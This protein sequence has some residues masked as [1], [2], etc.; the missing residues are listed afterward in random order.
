MQDLSVTPFS[1]YGSYLSISRPRQENSVPGAM[2]VQWHA[3]RAVDDRELFR[4]EVLCDGAVVSCDE[5]FDAGSLRL[6]HA[7]G[8]IAFGIE[9]GD[10][11]RVHGQGGL[12]LRLRAKLGTAVVAHPAEGDTWVV[13]HRPS[14]THSLIEP[15]VG[16][17]AVDA[18][19]D[20]D[21]ASRI[22]V[23]LTPDA[24]GNFDTAIDQ[25]QSTWVPGDRPAFDAVVESSAAHFADWLTRQPDVPDRLA[26]AREHAAYVNWALMV[27]PRGMLKRPSM[28]MSK[29]WMDQV[30][31]WDHCFNAIALSYKHGE[32]AW[33]QL[34]IMADHQDAFGA[35]P[36]GL[37]PHFKHYNFSK[38][39]V[40]GWALSKCLERSPQTFTE[41]RLRAAYEMLEAW[42]RW[43]T[44][45]RVMEGQHLPYYLHGNDSGWDNSTLFKDGTPLVSPDLAAFLV[46]QMEAMSEIAGRLGSDRE[47]DVWAEASQVMLGAL[48]GELW[49]GERF[50]AKKLPEQ[51]VMAGHSLVAHMPIVLGKRLPREVIAKTVEHL[52]GFVTAAGLATERTDSELYEAD[53]YW[54]GP[55]WGPSTM[56]VVDGLLDCGERELATTIAKRYCAT[57]AASGFAENFDAQTGASLRDPAYSW[58]SSV[59]LILAHE[60]LR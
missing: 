43:W 46:L 45:H 30:W 23:D 28:L 34:M 21:A 3:S 58:T 10:T 36:D 33:D 6:T 18:P 4:V 37:N 38:P 40:H 25:Y 19:W 7:D 29:F 53:G 17:L 16:G 1:R 56:L 9:P 8:S 41:S 24:A 60:L 48:L 12:T 31:S 44:T 5:T 52:R 57:C 22:T 26:A 35:F 50:V 20:R 42:T 32:L 55:M 49:T 14:R 54:R 2:W 15:I 51:K 59:F 47:H 11:L 27:E 39:P 13:N